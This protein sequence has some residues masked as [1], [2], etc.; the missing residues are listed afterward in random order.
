M[1]RAAFVVLVAILVASCGLQLE[2]LAASVTAHT[3]P[4]AVREDLRA[5]PGSAGDRPTE[6]RS[7][8]LWRDFRAHVTVAVSVGV[9]QALLITA[10]MFERRRRQSAEQEAR[11][12]L[13]NA[14]HL[15]RRAALGDLGAVLVHE[16]NQ[17]LGSI[18][19]NAEAAAIAIESGQP[20]VEEL[21]E[22]IADIR[23]EDLRASEIISRMRR[24]L[25][26]HEL[27]ARPLDV[28]DLT[29]ATLALVVP[30]AAN[31]GVCVD[32][33]LTAGLPPVQ[34]DCVHLQQVLLNVLL[35]GIDSMAAAPRAHRRLI[36][37]TAQS[38]H[39]VEIS[40]KD[41]GCGIAPD[42]AQEIFEPFYTTKA[43]GMGVGLSI[44]RSIIEAH[45]GQIDA[46]NNGDRGATVRFTIPLGRAVA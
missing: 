5:A 13:V 36:V 44:A 16:L 32:L 19:H 40:V 7:P 43:Q 6:F 37:G 29:R 23:R 28:N 14:A 15:D 42:A 27:D 46:K 8:G 25:Q 18:L 39:C 22:I 31:K 4:H 1:I 9:M 2:L 20:P 30:A 35:N 34:G 21:R 17:P 24:L 33:E 11:R 45:G 10:L 12:H 41:S 38:D 26:K 3:L